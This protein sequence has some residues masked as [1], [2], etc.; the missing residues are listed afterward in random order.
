MIYQ[1]VP[2]SMTLMNPN[3]DFKARYYPKLNISETVQDRHI[4]NRILIGIY[5]RPSQRCNFE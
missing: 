4:Y 1:T 2:F 5:T 3:S